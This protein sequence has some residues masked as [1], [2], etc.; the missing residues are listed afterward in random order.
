MRRHIAAV[1]AP[2]SATGGACGG[3]PHTRRD[4]RA[5]TSH[6]AILPRNPRPVHR[7]MVRA[8]RETPPFAPPPLTPALSSPR[9]GEGNSAIGD[10]APPTPIGGR[11]QGEVGTLGRGDR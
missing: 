3:L 1:Q 8:V 4:T 5:C 2:G 9:G 6:D 11:G 10:S 7:T